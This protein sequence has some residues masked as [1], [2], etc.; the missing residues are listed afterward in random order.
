MRPSRARGS[1]CPSCNK[2]E[3][4]RGRLIVPLRVTYAW[5][6]ALRTAPCATRGQVA[7]ARRSQFL[8]VAR[9]APNVGRSLDAYGIAF[10]WIRYV[11]YDDGPSQQRDHSEQILRGE[12]P[13]AP[14]REARVEP[15][16]PEPEEPNR[17]NRYQVGCG[18]EEPVPGWL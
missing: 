13:K 15:E 8:R 7:H 16:E 3:E 6:C 10:R 2:R 5:S 12:R 11:A 1:S 9:L 14:A 17:R 4:K 18:R